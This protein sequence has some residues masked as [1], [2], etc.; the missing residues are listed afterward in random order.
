MMNWKKPTLITIITV[1]GLGKP[2]GIRLKVEYTPR[3]TGWAIANLHRLS[4]S[5]YTK[6]AYS[7]LVGLPLT[8]ESALGILELSRKCQTEG[9]FRISSE[10][11][12]I[13]LDALISPKSLVGYLNQLLQAL[14]TGG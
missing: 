7:V 9:S 12:S 10:L 1:L 14:S 8:R 4:G 5:P 3:I 6:Q 13:T 2:S 11:G